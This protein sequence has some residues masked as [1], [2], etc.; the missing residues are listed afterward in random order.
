MTVTE[1]DVKGQIADMREAIESTR[2]SRRMS[3]IVSIVGVIVGFGIVI[4]FLL[5][6]WG[7]AKDVAA[8]PDA[9]Q[10][11]ITKRVEVFGLQRKLTS[12]V[13]KV[14]PVYMK[15]GQEALQDADA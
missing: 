6:L 14:V 10:Q 11:E 13:E 7:L 4:A 1:Q 3:R 2:V 15:A 12:V 5:S 9:I 8:Q